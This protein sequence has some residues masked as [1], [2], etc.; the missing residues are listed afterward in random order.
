MTTGADLDIHLRYVG[1]RFDGARLPLDVLVDLP[2]FRDL[3]VAYAKEQWKRQNQ[4]RIRVPKGFEKSLSF[5]LTG[6][7]DGSAMPALRWEREEA[8]INLPEIVGELSELV[9]VAY[10]EVR[11]LVARAANDEYPRALSPEQV[12]ALN[13]FGSGLQD[14]ERIEFLSDDGLDQDVIY[15][16]S[17]RRKRLIV[18]LRETYES[19]YEDSGE[20]MGVQRVNEKQGHLTVRTTHFG[21]IRVD[22]D[23][24][25]VKEFDG[26]IGAAVEFALQIELDN[27][28]VFRNI[29][30]VH[31]VALEESVS[32]E[33][34][35]RL[36][37]LL[38]LSSG[39]DDGAGAAVTENAA[40]SA[41]SFLAK[42]PG[43]TG[44][45]KIFPTPSGGLLIDFE[46][47]GWDLSIEFEPDGSVELFGIEIE[48]DGELS[49]LS[50]RGPNELFFAAFDQRVPSR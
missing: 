14:G 7:A 28:D 17:E 23:A 21:D 48:G 19:R 50:F 29:V 1:H 27:A 35:E 9:Q 3:L 34:E 37:E 43:H 31:R 45:Y 47:N 44:T 15:L 10:R 30:E 46:A 12:R 24:D 11:G 26:N 36:K 41:R 22:I 6:I 18:N 33:H 38:A 25:R 2:A 42:R 32:V 40:A 13:K 5:S 4:D 8:Q 16:D 39:W 49:P 20:L